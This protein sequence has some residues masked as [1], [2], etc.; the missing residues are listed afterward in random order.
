MT[1]CTLRVSVPHTILRVE[2]LRSLNIS[3]Q[4][5]NISITFVIFC[6]V[7]IT[8]SI[9]NYAFGIR[10]IC[11]NFLYALKQTHYDFCS[12]TDVP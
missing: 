7:K 9:G 11:I 4:N 8:I 12:E 5:R 10:N 2:L 6:D 1:E 3:I